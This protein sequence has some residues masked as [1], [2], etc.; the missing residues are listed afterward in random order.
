M[1]YS[2]KV[3]NSK[4]L[5][6]RSLVAHF[7]ILIWFPG[8]LAAAWWQVTVALAG[9]SLGWLYSVEW[10][11]FA[12]FGSVFWWNIIHDNPDEVGHKG[13]ILARKRMGYQDLDPSAVAIDLNVSQQQTL[14]ERKDGETAEIDIVNIRQIADSDAEMSAYNE[15]LASLHRQEKSKKRDY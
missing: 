14:A 8:C 11:I 2:F 10:P 6:K 12:I 5:T 9:D 4:W 7:A 1:D 13:L 15:Y 3:A